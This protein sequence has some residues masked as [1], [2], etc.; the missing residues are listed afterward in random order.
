M[1]SP[2]GKT[3]KLMD[4]QEAFASRLRETRS[5]RGL[6][7]K[8]LGRRVG[9]TGGAIA[10]YELGRRMPD[11]RIAVILA[12]AL[13]IDVAY[14]VGA[15]DDRDRAGR[16]VFLRDH[17]PLLPEDVLQWIVGPAA[18]PYVV[19]AKELADRKLS[20]DTLRGMA[21][22]INAEASRYAQSGDQN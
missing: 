19:M 1:P 4:T 3:T 5:Q 12:R 14:L 18:A 22:I 17:L 13:D 21:E 10:G 20:P 2:R 11:I 9:L 6:S 15:T 16:S 8:E 7:Q